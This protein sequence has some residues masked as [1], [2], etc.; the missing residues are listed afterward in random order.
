MTPSYVTPPQTMT[1]ER[2][3]SYSNT[4]FGLE[5][6][7]YTIVYVYGQVKFCF[8]GP[9]HTVPTVGSSSNLVSI[10]LKAAIRIIFIQPVDESRMKWFQFHIFQYFTVLLFCELS[11]LRTDGVLIWI[12]GGDDTNACCSRFLFSAVFAVFGLPA[13]GI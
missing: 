3:S 12:Y 2:L 6:R 9:H 11:V 7:Q 13:R 10:K 5:S 4:T 1:P 8:I